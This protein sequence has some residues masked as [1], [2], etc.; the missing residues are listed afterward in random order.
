VGFS[1]GYTR[2]Y[3]STL[4]EPFG[5]GGQLD[6]DLPALK[7]DLDVGF[8]PAPSDLAQLVQHAL[9]GM[10]PVVKA[11]L[12]LPN[13]LIELKD[14]KRPALKVVSVLQ[15]ASWFE[16]L[17]KLGWLVPKHRYKATFKQLLQ[18]TAGHYLNLQFN[19]LPLISDIAKI[20]SAMSRTERRMN[21]FITRAGRPQSKHYVYKW[22]EFQDVVNETTITGVPW[23]IPD[24]ACSCFASRRVTYDPTVFH[25]QIQY[26]YNYTGYQ[27]EHA[28]LLAHLD[29]LGVNLNPA[30]IWNAIP[31]SFVVD[32]VAG[33]SPY[34]DSLKTENMR[35]LI[36]I[37]R[38]LWSV[39]RK[40]R[41]YVQKG[42]VDATPAQP[43]LSMNQMPVVVQSAYRRSVGLPSLSSITS[44]GLTPK[45]VSLGA[46]LVIARRR[47]R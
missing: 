14:F 43:I 40:R 42:T 11:E 36:N 24:I 18:G 39:G 29:S 19:V 3:P 5:D 23:V 6:A 21:D 47:R 7:S 2:A 15:S 13:F 9:T 25:A 38:F 30:I 27:V 45:E 1:G 26:N 34:L 12:S 35:P 46:A 16:A 31:W 33:V 20:R 41:I 4:V 22:A 10:L 32:W 37:R 17:K 28:Q 44:S 8:I